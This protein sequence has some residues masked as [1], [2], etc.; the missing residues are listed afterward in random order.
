M[1]ALLEMLA[2]AQLVNKFHAIYGKL[3]LI[4]VFTESRK[5]KREA[6]CNTWQLLGL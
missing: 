2:V 3:N 4:P 1:E 6:Q 5:T